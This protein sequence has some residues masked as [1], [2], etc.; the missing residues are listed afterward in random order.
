MELW[1]NF[2]L[3]WELNSGGTYPPTKLFTIFTYHGVTPEVIMS[4]FS[5]RKISLMYSM[6]CLWTSSRSLD[7]WSTTNFSTLFLSLVYKSNSCNNRNHIIN[8]G[9]TYF[10]AMRYVI[11]A[12]SVYTIW[13]SPSMVWTCQM[14]LQL[15]ITLSQCCCCWF[16]L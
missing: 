5:S 12:W 11:A 15:L 4:G 3:C 14:Q 1:K 8:L 13:C 2:F 16:E 10:F 6:L 9:L 7:K